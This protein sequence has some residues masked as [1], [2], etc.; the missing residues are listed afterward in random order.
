[1]TNGEGFDEEATQAICFCQGFLGEGEE[2]NLAC[3]CGSG[4]AAGGLLRELFLE[5]GVWW[6]QSE[7]T[8]AVVQRLWEW[9]A[10]FRNTKTPTEADAAQSLVDES[11]QLDRCREMP[12]LSA[13]AN[14]VTQ[15]PATR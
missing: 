5:G 6:W 3:L 10:F 14:R 13:G 1:M 2:R 4:S 8:A 9:P 11:V 15:G 7:Q 12:C